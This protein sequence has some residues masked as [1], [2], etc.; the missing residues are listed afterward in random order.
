MFTNLY[1]YY[2]WAY[3]SFRTV[4]K[5]LVVLLIFV[6]ILL[7]LPLLL[8]NY[9]ENFALLLW[10]TLL[11]ISL[12]WRAFI[13]PLLPYKERMFKIWINIKMLYVSNL[14]AE[15]KLIKLRTRDIKG[16]ILHRFYLVPIFYKLLQL[17]YFLLTS[18]FN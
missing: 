12:H 14:N 16:W 15:I 8:Q 7:K 17:C 1:T 3:L 10:K 4:L 18:R 2:I 5:L 6:F 11:S 9:H 13:C